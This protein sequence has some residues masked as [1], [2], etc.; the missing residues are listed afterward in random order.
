MADGSLTY[1]RG[2]L[3][4]FTNYIKHIPEEIEA[5]S[6]N[7]DGNWPMDCNPGPVKTQDLPLF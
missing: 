1:Q 4:S 5:L 6:D 2:F 3:V 7:L